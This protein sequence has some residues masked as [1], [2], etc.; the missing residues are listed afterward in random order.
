MTL[1]EGA[2][3]G[4]A[5]GAP[6]RRRARSLRAHV[7][8][9]G[10]V[11]VALMPLVGTGASFSADE[12][13][14]IIQAQSL[15]RGDGWIVEHPVPPVGESVRSYPLELSEEGTKGV[16]PFA[17]HPLYAVLLAAA[18]RV[19][20]VTGMVLLSVLGTL[21]AAA[22]AALI[23]GRL[24][25]GVA[26]PTLWVV[27]VASPLLFDGYLVIAH[28]LAAASVAAAVLVA[29]VAWERRS[30]PFA[31]LVAPLMATAVMLRSEAVLFALALAAVLVGAALL[32]L[33]T[34]RGGGTRST[35][36]SSAGAAGAGVAGV[37]GVA[38]GAGA[39]AAVAAGVGALGARML[40]KSWAAAIVGPPAMSTVRPRAA[41]PSG[42]LD[43]RLNAFAITWLRPS[44]NGPPALDAALVVMLVGVALG[45]FI[46]RR[47]PSD[48][49]G[50]KF[51]AVLTIAAA[52]VGFLIGPGNL[53]PGLLVA[54]P[55]G[56]AGLLALDRIALRTTPARILLGAFALFALAVL[57]TQYA[58]GGTA[59][60][61]GRYFAIGLP[62]L[63]PVVVLALRR[64]AHHRVAAGA[65]IAATAFMS[66]MSVAS[67]RSSHLF[68]DEL[69]SAVDR[70]GGEVHVATSGAIP[71]L[72]W[73]TFDRQR[74]LLVAP[75][76][77]AGVMGRLR[78]EGVERVTFVTRDAA[79]ELPR[80]G[81][82]VEV[83]GTT[84]TPGNGWSIHSLSLG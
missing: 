41:D 8:A 46:A 33:V 50:L 74:W 67:I 51:A 72:A 71:R 10:V 69:I 49:A 34:D 58:A 31:A 75:G 21:V 84:P 29:L 45:V 61:G 20:G 48:Q 79:G 44:H 52:L 78:A 82:S 77:L 23:A 55:I 13:A 80:L 32:E 81:A 28:S 68:T 25:P 83:T 56:F 38:G 73:S 39:A 47:R 3:R 63:A 59:E 2:E 12:G 18:D 65:L 16:A 53:V 57:A 15:S 26:K 60:W 1:V 17:K 19:G 64:H 43:G 7:A 66:V 40:E 35:V 24:A 42:F 4:A 22:L 14:A 9:L 37:A 54:F 27:G 30:A 70:A 62:A 11:L 6:A 5:E 76:D 36:T